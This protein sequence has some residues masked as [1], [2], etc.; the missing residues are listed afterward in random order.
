MTENGTYILFGLM[1]L[2]SVG[3]IAA[4]LLLFLQLRKKSL[5]T[6][7]VSAPGDA[8]KNEELKTRAREIIVEAKDEAI[9]LRREAEND[10]NRRRQEIS[11]LEQRIT[12]K[13]EQT[14]RK[15]GMLDE[16][17][18]HLATKEKELQEREVGIENIKK[19]QLEKLQ[20]VAG[21]TKDE[22][23]NLI[24]SA[25]EKNLKG[26]IAKRIR[27]TEEEAKAESD[28]KAQEILVTAIQKASTDYVAE[29]TTSTVALPNDEM[30]GRIIGRE[31]RN[32]KSFEN[33]SGVNV[34]I[35]ETPGVITLSSFDGVRREIAKRSM[36]KLI[37]DGRIQ[38]SRIEEVMEKTRK[39]VE[40]I[41]HDAGEQLVYD[42]GV[43]GLPRE[44][45]DL[46][47]RFKFRTSYGQNMITHT[48]EVVN[49]GKA[50]A[51]EVGADTKTVKAACLLHDLGKVLTADNEGSHT[52]LGADVL[53][54]HK[55]PEKIIEAMESHH[56]EKPFTSVEGI[57]VAVADA[58]SG[59]RPGA[60]FEDYESY[61]KRISDI[62]NIAASF[63]GVD[64]AFA[65]QAGREVRVIVVPTQVDDAGII[66]M[67]HDIAGKIH[68]GV[69]YPGTVK[70]TVVRENR[71]VEVAK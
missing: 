12:Q 53:R 50:L 40:K 59:A 55:M 69:V 70:V 33:A 42:A 29:Y 34:E 71:A 23:K 63:E 11:K 7:V 39:E 51:S 32:I 38:P 68:D 37:S 10:V 43:P 2:L 66:T 41:I 24:I 3:T 6:S 1:L 14:D 8:Q 16:R 57:L 45:I 35:D 65:L 20:R 54:R 48:L 31:G 28:K 4:V 46:L 22:A 13:D 52:T 9:R 61:V 27:E 25:V 44:I 49:L 30:K 17:E 5:T 47:G 56:E 18:R 58:I 15:M 26:E 21:L 64:K 36:E 60:R 19:E 62:E 67:A